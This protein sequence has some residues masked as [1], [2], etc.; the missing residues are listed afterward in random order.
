[1]NVLDLGSFPFAGYKGIWS[2]SFP[3]HSLE[4]FFSSFVYAVMQAVADDAIR[5]T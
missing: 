5:D 2:S 3:L 4:F 1:M